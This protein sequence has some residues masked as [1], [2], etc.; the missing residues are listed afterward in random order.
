[1]SAS[2]LLQ[3]EDS[4]LIV[5]DVQ[6]NF[7]CKLE[8]E[9]SQ[10]LLE[11]VA[12][13]IGVAQWLKIPVLVTVEDL[14]R[15]GGPSPEVVQALPPNTPIFN[16]MIFSLA[17]QPDILAAVERLQRRTLVLVGLE[18][19][20]C[21]MQS[22]LGLLERGYRVAVI[23]DATGSPGAAHASGL[24]RMPAAG[25]LMT[26]TKGLFYEWVRTVEASR[27]FEAECAHLGVPSGLV[28]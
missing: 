7:T 21:V 15:A 26:D 23:T 20:V 28:L 9:Q 27:C 3:A 1:V 14:P 22:A 10:R 17:H 12:W 24:A 5:I 11:R 16:K 2:A 13:L 8:A 4:A 6:D 19:D 18:T 25:V